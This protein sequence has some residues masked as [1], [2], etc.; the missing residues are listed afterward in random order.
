[1]VFPDFLGIGAQKSGTTW[2]E[3]NLRTHPKIWMPKRKEIHYFDKI[4]ERGFND[5]WY[6]SLF[7]PEEGQ[8]SGEITPAYSILNECTIAYAHSLMPEARLIFLMRNPI[9][10]AWSSATMVFARGRKRELATVREE[11]FRKLFDSA[12]GIHWRSDYP[13]TLENWSKFYPEERIFVGFLEEIHFHPDSL[14]HRLYEFLGVEP[15]A[16]SQAATQ[17]IHTWATEQIPMTLAT[18]LARIYYE[19][20]QWLHQRF[21]GYASFWLY[22]AE[23]LI[24]GSVAEQ[25]IPYPLYD[26]QLWAN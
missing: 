22:C 21:G 18:Y 20:L 2:L 19:R 4:R 17:R 11:E 9:E 12:S 23:R 6:A 5:K 15:S 26:S 14:L 10:R 24:E 3:K 8:I 25:Y 16:Q 13:R 1:M 7:R